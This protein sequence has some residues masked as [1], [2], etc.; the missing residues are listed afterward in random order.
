[1][2]KKI[3][4]PVGFHREND[5][6]LEIA[7]KLAAQNKSKITLLHVVETVEHLEFKEMEDFYRKLEKNAQEELDQIA[8]EIVS[9]DIQVQKEILFGRRPQEIVN[10]ATDNQIDLIVLSSH[11]VDPEKGDFKDIST[12]SYKVSIFAP[13]PV[14]LVK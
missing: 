10:F 11:R 3:L 14:L 9:A 2:F 4:I 1:M 7:K 5:P 6:T 13:C 8:K 12:I